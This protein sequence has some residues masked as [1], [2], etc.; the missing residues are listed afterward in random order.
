MSRPSRW[1][2]AGDRR[3]GTTLR[4]PRLDRWS[5]LAAAVGSTLTCIPLVQL[6]LLA[7]V[8]LVFAAARGNARPGGLERASA[9]I[10]SFSALVPVGAPLVAM[11]PDH[12][13]RVPWAILGVL[14]AALSTLG[15]GA[16]GRRLRRL[17]SGTPIRRSVALLLSAGRIPIAGVMLAQ[18]HVPLDIISPGAPL[19]SGL[20]L[21]AGL[22]WL[23]L[24]LG[25][26]AAASVVT[27]VRKDG[28]LRLPGPSVVEQTARQWGQRLVADRRFS[29]DRHERGFL[30]RGEVGGLHVAVDAHTASDDARLTVRV[31]LPG[32]PSLA[33]IIVAARGDHAADVPLPDPILHDMIRVSGVTAKEAAALLGGLHE[34][35]FEVL[36]A[37]EE[38]RI[39][40]GCVVAVGEVVPTDPSALTVD[41]VMGPAIL[42]AQ[43]LVQQ[44]RRGSGSTAD[45]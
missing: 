23:D 39:S 35:L 21:L 9:L 18:Q 4:T 13:G 41:A 43:A 26:L 12:P 7:R 20:V 34:P 8:P 24:G 1:V 37:H 44:T 5:W 30:A 32:P 19:P 11:A 28:A 29:V 25:A 16:L 40:G 45:T 42:L 10:G 3:D 22:A 6:A 33:T 36:H 14:L 15:H 31:T 2:E 38:S 17:G 27:L